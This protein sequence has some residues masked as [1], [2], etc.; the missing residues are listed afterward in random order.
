LSTDK[1]MQAIKI[2]GRR[3]ARLFATCLFTLPVVFLASVTLFSFDGYTAEKPILIGSSISQTGAFARSARG[4]FRS[5][6]LAAEQIKGPI[7]VKLYKKLIYQDKVDFL[8]SPFGRS[9][10]LRS[11][12]LS[13]ICGPPKTSRYDFHISTSINCSRST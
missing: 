13:A 11:L 2:C 4:Q 12:L 3:R 5:F 9:H 6:T 10:M 1:H 8:L 7:A